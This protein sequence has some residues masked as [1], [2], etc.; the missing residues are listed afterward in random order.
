[1]NGIYGA[2]SYL[3]LKSEEFVLVYFVDSRAVAFVIRSPYP[4]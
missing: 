4:S 1:M 3:H 2:Y